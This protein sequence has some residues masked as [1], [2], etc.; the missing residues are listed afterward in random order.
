MQDRN[1]NISKGLVLAAA[2]QE[3]KENKINDPQQQI[4][5]QMQEN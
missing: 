2:A 5:I 1:L 3:I 4:K